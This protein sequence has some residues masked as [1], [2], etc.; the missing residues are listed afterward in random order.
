MRTDMFRLAVRNYLYPMTEAEVWKELALSIERGDTDRA[1]CI[2]DYLDT[3]EEF[4]DDCDDEKP[5]FPAHWA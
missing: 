2:K 4:A 1:D 3:E 5:N